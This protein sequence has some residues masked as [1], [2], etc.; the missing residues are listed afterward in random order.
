MKARRLCLKRPETKGPT[1]PVASAGAAAA[2]APASL[3]GMKKEETLRGDPH[4]PPK[5]RAS[6]S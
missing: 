6:R 2:A 3:S 4:T 5:W 1:T